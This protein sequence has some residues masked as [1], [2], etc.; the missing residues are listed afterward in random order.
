MMNKNINI[1]N[2]QD[3][4]LAQMKSGALLNPRIDSTFKALFTQPTAE[5]RNALHSFLEAATERKI[6]SVELTANEAPIAFE[7]QRSVSYD[8]LCI[9]DDGQPANLEMM[10]F[11][12]FYDYGKR[13]EYQ[14]ARL[15]TTYL[16]KGDTWEKAPKVY[17]ITV[18]DFVYDK[19]T[20]EPISRYAM[21]TA[22]NR[23]L[24]NTLNIIFI[25]LPKVTKLENSIE[26][27]T[28]LENWA[29]FLKDADNPK[30]TKV[31]QKL[32]ET[33]AGLMNAKQSLSSIS[34]NQELW[35]EQ[36]RQEMFERDYRSGLSAAENI[37]LERGLKEGITKGRAEGEQKGKIVLAKKYMDM[38][39][40]A[41]EAAD[42]A[43]IDVELLK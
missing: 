37:G 8:I 36:F 15:E 18:L 40:T 1:Y 26:K 43:E 33:E 41:Q 3:E 4:Y 42:F 24:S 38:G 30:K 20:E 19:S 12:Q 27:N 11:N 35:V 6:K 29:I 9:F 22:D 10:A 16:K 34:A 25:E 7:K 28:A 2:S 31:I 5:S 14:V 17:Q 39:H 32:T 23:E 13:A 21:R